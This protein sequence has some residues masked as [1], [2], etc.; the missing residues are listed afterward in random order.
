MKKIIDWELDIGLYPGVLFGVRS[1][2]ENYFTE[3]AFYIPFIDIILTLHY[4]P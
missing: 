1:Y 4:E 2:V 3:I